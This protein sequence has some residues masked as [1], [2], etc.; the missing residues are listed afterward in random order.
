[1]RV[2]LPVGRWERSPGIEL[3]SP[4]HRIAQRAR[5]RTV[6]EWY[7]SNSTMTPVIHITNTTSHRH[8]CH[9]TSPLQG[10]G[11]EPGLARLSRSHHTAVVGEFVQHLKAFQQPV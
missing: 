5:V 7:V 4:R 1:V 2:C 10:N 9:H 6:R 3:T 11:G 8:T